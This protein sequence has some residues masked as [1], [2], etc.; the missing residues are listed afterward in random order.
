MKNLLAILNLF[1]LFNFLSCAPQ[2]GKS[3]LKISVAAVTGSAQFPGG[4][5]IMAKN[6]RTNQKLIRRVLAS[7]SIELELDNGLWSFAA[8]GWEG[9]EIFTGNV[10][11]E[12]LVSIELKGGDFPLNFKTS[13]PKCALPLFGGVVDANHQFL[14]LKLQSCMDIK[15]NIMDNSEVFPSNLDCTPGNSFEVL[16][17]GVKSFKVSVAQV[18][19]NGSLD[20]AGGLSS[21]C[22][23]T[24][25]GAI[26]TLIK[27]PFGSSEFPMKYFIEGYDSA[28]CTSAPR[29]IYK[30]SE[31]F[32]QNALNDEAIALENPTEAYINIALNALACVGD[33]LAAGNDFAAGSGSGPYLICTKKQFENIGLDSSTRGYSYIL[34]QDILFGGSN[35]TISTGAFTGSLDGRDHA[36]V[37]GNQPLFAI[38]NPSNTK[39]RIRLSNFTIDTFKLEYTALSATKNIGILAEKVSSNSTGNELEISDITIKGSSYIDIAATSG[40]PVVHAGGLI[41]EVDFSTSNT[42][43]KLSIR[44]ID[45]FSSVVGQDLASASFCVGGLV[46][47][48]KSHDSNGQV[49]FEENRVGVTD[50]L[51]IKNTGGRVILKSDEKVGGLV[52]CAGKLDIRGGNIAITEISANGYIGGILGEAQGGPNGVQVDSTY[53]DLIAKSLAAS[54]D[55]V[56]GVI[57]SVPGGAHRTT[58]SSVIANLKI[59]E[60]TNLFSNVGGIIG[61]ATGVSTADVLIL[62]SKAVLNVRS[63][64]S[65]YGGIIGQYYDSSFSGA[66]DPPL[67]VNSIAEG[68]IDLVNISSGSNW[69]GGIA[70]KMKSGIAKRVIVNFLKIIGDERNSGGYGESERSYLTESYIRVNNLISHSVAPNSA[71]VVGYWNDLGFSSNYFDSIKLDISTSYPTLGPCSATNKCGSIVGQIASTPANASQF[72]NIVDINNVSGVPCGASTGGYCTGLITSIKT[73]DADCSTISGIMDDVSTKC[74]PIFKRRWSEF[75]EKSPNVNAGEFLAGNA[76]EPFPLISFS[77]WNEIGTDALL[78]SK[79]FELKDNL[80]FNGQPFIPL[81]GDDNI[82]PQP[83]GFSG[84]IISNGLSLKD[85]TY[86]TSNIG[87]GGQTSGGL[88]PILHG[89]GSVGT[90]G[91]PLRIENLNLTCDVNKCGV[92]GEAQGGGIFVEVFKGTITGSATA[93][94]GGLLGYS[95]GGHVEISDSGFNGRLNLA[96]VTGLGGLVGEYTGSTAG[97]RID[98]SYA[99]LE[100]IIGDASVGGIIGEAPSTS[101]DFS[102]NNSYVWLDID[103]A[104]NGTEDINSTSGQTGGII[105][106]LTGTVEIDNV[107]VDYSKAGL[108]AMFKSIIEGIGTTN[109]SP[110]MVAIGSPAAPNTTGVS[111]DEVSQKQAFEN[112]FSNE[113][114]W[115]L[116]DGRILLD[117]EVNGFNNH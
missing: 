102:I 116:K 36:L 29:Y 74:E 30:F 115:V 52:G 87:A 95:S 56:G 34:G 47:W 71:G 81:G 58:I 50:I 53:S 62:N 65:F 27:L 83:E 111:I 57:G 106:N 51:D 98:D 84:G 5:L 103:E 70:G 2:P 33:H 73:S 82:A 72:T 68:T 67:I 46:G 99:K 110:V 10:Q 107:Y 88:F 78:I 1:L 14:P 114:D 108:P 85:I 112:N 90:R 11:C 22:Q 69:R 44:E 26:D 18:L 35:T 21:K 43:D 20:A 38:I 54:V 25:G 19:V 80:Y 28:D 49:V 13:S 59:D 7:D 64:G 96:G 48:A 45:S 4:L 37:N 79:W 6:N 12:Q 63:D 76:I 15:S 9:D 61:S 55:R 8:I 92:V 94:V 91:E 93:S 77:D 60:P 40:S 41:G 117:W 109:A 97:V 75:S 17:G 16:E 89:G 23:P 32:S 24:S 86:V 42:G 104:H 31:G 100:Y 113:K 66:S 101:E 39:N 3:N 105:G